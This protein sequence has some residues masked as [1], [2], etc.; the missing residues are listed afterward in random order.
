VASLA[1]TANPPPHIGTQG[2]YN[3]PRGCRGTWGS[4]G[5]P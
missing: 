2:E 1:P 4:L 3:T 5:T